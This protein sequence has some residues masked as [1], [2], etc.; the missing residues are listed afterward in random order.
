MRIAA[1]LSSSGFPVQ[2]FASMRSSLASSVDASPE[3][4]ES[5]SNA[6]SANSDFHSIMGD[7]MM[8]G[9]PLQSSSSGRQ[10]PRDSSEAD[11]STPQSQAGSSASSGPPPSA[12]NAPHW[13]AS[14]VQ[15]SN[16]SSQTKSSDSSSQSGSQASSD[17]TADTSSSTSTDLKKLLLNGS[18]FGDLSLDQQDEADGT[19]GAANAQ[20]NENDAAQTASGGQANTT[21]A[22]AALLAQR[23][24]AGLLAATILGLDAKQRAGAALTKDDLAGT[25]DSLSQS[26][27]AL[28][29]DAGS[30]DAAA[31]GP[32]GTLAGR[33]SLQLNSPA[34]GDAD[35]GDPRIQEST[36]GA[37]NPND[38]VA[39][40][41]KLSPAAGSA[42]NS[43]NGAAQETSGSSDQGASKQSSDGSADDASSALVVSAP[44]L[45]TALE[46]PV[47]P[48]AAQ[49]APLPVH[50][51]TTSPA[52]APADSSAAARMQSMIEAPSP[53]AS[54]NH[55]ILVKVPGATAGTGI[56]LRFVERAGD[57]HLSVRTPSS[58][59]AQQLRGGL[60]DLVGK[61]DHAGIRAEIS[62]P[63]TGDAQLS[64]QSK[65]QNNQQDSS[66]DRR[67]GRNQAD[68][69][70]QQQPSREQNQSQWFQ[71]L[72]DSAGQ[73]ETSNF[74]KEQSI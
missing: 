53:L 19:E 36:S 50:Q 44:A 5:F 15:I 55:S 74:S 11:D 3:L 67:G 48:Q 69:Q 4:D 12:A 63:S 47:A 23:A 31:A 42:N 33:E 51:P 18:L 1:P 54:S 8:D 40:E 61:L 26:L 9:Q 57:I 43:T 62:N 35:P 58:E 21:T 16:R 13:H 28:A 64:N 27:S 49:A 22:A 41:A 20:S 59:V 14:S 7:S 25:G 34:D 73:D 46:T 72:A 17:A 38:Q 6:S 52:A 70:S 71:A 37:S 45:K 10:S 32:A 66:P 29:P 68:S 2:A 56:D 30:P 65:D 60:N 24:N 39:F